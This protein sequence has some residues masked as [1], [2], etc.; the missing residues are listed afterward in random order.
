M[1]GDGN[2]AIVGALAS[3]AVLTLYVCAEFIR[4]HIRRYRLKNP[5]KARFPIRPLSEE[6]ISYLIQDEETHSVEE[7]VLP[8]NSEVEIELGFFA[9]LS[10]Y[11]TDIIFQCEGD[12][13]QRPIAIERFQR[14]VKIGKKR[15]KPGKDESES[16]DIHGSYHCRLDRARNTGTHFVIGFKIKTRGPGRYKTKLYFL[17]TEV[18]GNSTL[19][20][21]VEDRPHTRMRCRTKGHHGC[22][23]RPNSGWRADQSQ[24]KGRRK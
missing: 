7:L 11:N 10:F 19:S 24:K 9:K 18:E 20:I 6:N 22:F 1:F 16:I 4:P 14:L 13:D 15:W 17:T 21:R 3:I 2:W 23:V 12:P 8:S 5:C